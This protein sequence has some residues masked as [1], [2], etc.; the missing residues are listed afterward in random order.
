MTSAETPRPRTLVVLPH[1]DDP[2]YFCGGS[3]ARWIDEGGE[4][5]YCLL[6]SGERGSDD[7]ATDPV[8]LARRR[9]AEQRRAAAVLGVREVLFLGY[10]DGELAATPDLARDLVRVIRR[11]RP[12]RVVTCDPSPVTDGFL[13]HS[14]H[15]VAGQATLD[16]VYP[17]A[18]SGMYFPDLEREEGLAPHKVGE[19]YIGFAADAN[20]SLDVTDQLDRKA[21]ALREH[22]SQIRK[23]QDLE[24][25]L[26]E[27]MRD[28][29][30]PPEAPRYVERFLRIEMEAD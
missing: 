21:A 12:T 24:S 18:G 13:N 16:A 28:P 30:S 29:Q 26:K 15:R 4:V 11:L 6:T 3:V 9:E 8:Q 23:P 20:L 17:A 10:P 19:V 1:P 2:E 22:R 25:R 14:D 5:I 7:A 27:W